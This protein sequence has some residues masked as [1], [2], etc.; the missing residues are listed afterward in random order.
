MRTC[1]VLDRRARRTAK[2]NEG[3]MN[4]SR[5]I[6]CVIMRMPTTVLNGREPSGAAM[7]ET[8]Q[9][10]TA[11]VPVCLLLCGS[12]GACLTLFAPGRNELSFA[13]CDTRS[14]L[15]SLRVHLVFASQNVRANV[16]DDTETP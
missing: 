3:V 16:T 6:S 7:S 2:S 9:A 13:S 15:H 4:R 5:R 8:H 10:A 11:S 1:L 12:F 14:T